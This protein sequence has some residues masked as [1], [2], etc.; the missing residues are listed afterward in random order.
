MQ[1][2]KLGAN[3]AMVKPL[4]LGKLVEAVSELRLGWLLVSAEEKASEAGSFRLKRDRF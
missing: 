3:A 2:Y 1:S 4:D